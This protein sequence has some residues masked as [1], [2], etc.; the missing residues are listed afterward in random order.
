MT[1]QKRKIKEAKGHRRLKN[2]LK[3]IAERCNFSVDTEVHLNISGSKDTTGKYEAEK[4]VDVLATFVHKGKHCMIFF[5]CKD[6]TA[7]KAIKKELSAW[8][9]DIG[10]ILSKQN[11]IK[12]T[13]SSGK[14]VSDKDFKQV[15]EIR[16]CF[17]FSEKLT[18]D[19]YEIYQKIMERYSFMIWNYRILKYYDKVSYVLEEWTKYDIFRELNF[20]FEIVN[21]HKEPAVKIKQGKSFPEMYI[22]GLHPGLLL[23]IGYVLR[24]TSNKPDAYQRVINKYRI[25]K[26]SEFLSSKEVLLPNSI[27][28]TFD[29]DLKIQK[30]IEYKNGHLKFPIQYCSAW[31]IDGQHRVY[32]FIKTKYKNWSIESNNDFK[33]PVL[34]FRKLD[35]ILQNKTFV[36]INYYQKKINPSLLCD[37]A[38]ATKDLKNELTWPSLLIVE[39]NKVPPLKDYVKVSEFDTGRPITLSSFARYGLLGTLLGFNKRKA[40]YNGPLYHY[41]YFYPKLKFENIKNQEAFKKQLNL[42]KRFFKGVEKNTKNTNKDKDPWR[43]L[44]NYSLLKTTGIN[45]LLLVLARIIEKYPKIDINLETYLKP[46]KKINF[47]REY[48]ANKGGGWKG[49]RSLANEIL[50]KLNEQNNDNLRLFGE[51]E[52]L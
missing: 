22:L 28:I 45:A 26:I 50:E 46:F 18:R 43:N 5:E 41:A 2:K 35:E 52:K 30:E 33:L 19:K 39:L 27:I 6:R 25:E 1:T 34:A 23:M 48:V 14:K 36:N 7:M 3:K 40:E 42:L 4:S 8:E 11:T 24:R 49:F 20:F 32:G 21:S 12:V 17:V 37:L 38:T 29:K 51:K 31:I 10:K 44:K 16:L 47:E 13:S 15:D 9:N